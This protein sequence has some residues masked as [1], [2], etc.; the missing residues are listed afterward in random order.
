MTPPNVRNCLAV[1][2]ALTT[3]GGC[4][5]TTLGPAVMRLGPGNPDARLFQLGIRSGPRLSAS[6]NSTSSTPFRG[7]TS[8]L[9]TQQWGLAYDAA[10]TFPVSERLSLHAGAQGEVTP[11]TVPMPGY[12]V[13]AGA[14][15]YLGTERVG[16]GP[17]LSVRGASDFGLTGRGGPGS[18]V[19][20]EATCALALQ[21][22]PGVSLGLV[23]FFSW[24]Q[25][26]A[27]EATSTW[28]LYYGAVLAARVSLGRGSNQV[29]L[30]GGFGRTRLGTGD[31][32]N[33]PI[34][35]VRGAR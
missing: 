17:A 35:G 25:T 4:A 32:W 26:F 16:L 7:D 5:P 9:A 20:A 2:C 22:E 18:M 11:M 27:R 6:L 21:P 23:P 14:S 12:G 29:E 33:V 3:L 1:A 28:A 8:T 19:G 15:Y 30:S 13:Y 10:L 24:N 31:R 34:V